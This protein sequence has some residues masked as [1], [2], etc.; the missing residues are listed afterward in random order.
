MAQMMTVVETKP[1]MKAAKGVLTNDEIRDVIAL[2][3]LDPLCGVL[4][5]DTGGIRKV[6]VPAKGKGKS[7]GARVIYYYYNE[8][9]PVF[10]FT[11]F[12][13]GMKE[14]LT[15]GER[16]LLAE[17]VKQELSSYAKK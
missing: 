16:N 6:R 11:V 2:I 17:A 5:Q 8:S 15:K 4:I 10:L 1:F 7:G 13:K 3:A 14:N 9:L 12:T